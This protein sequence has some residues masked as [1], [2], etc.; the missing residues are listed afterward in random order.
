MIT[1][2]QKQDRK[3][4]HAVKRRSLSSSSEEDRKGSRNSSSQ[5]RGGGVDKELAT[6][7]KLNDEVGSCVGNVRG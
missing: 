6:A 7:L 1:K 5:E 3:P 4:R 2:Y